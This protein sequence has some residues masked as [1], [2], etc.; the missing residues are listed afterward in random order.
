LFNRPE[1]IKIVGWL[2]FPGGDA[3]MGRFPLVAKAVAEVLPIV[4]TEVMPKPGI[5]LAIDREGNDDGPAPFGP[6]GPGRVRP[7]RAFDEEF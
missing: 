5:P 2:K 3:D 1:P 4:R 6:Q 7:R